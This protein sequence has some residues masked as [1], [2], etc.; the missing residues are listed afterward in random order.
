MT[1]K[2]FIAEEIPS[3]NKGEAAI[4]IGALESF[5]ILGDVK[6]SLLSF[7]AEIDRIRYPAKV[8]IIDAQ[9]DLHLRRFLFGN[10]LL[11][12]I[13]REGF[14]AFQLFLFIVFYKIFGS[15]VV[16]LMKAEIWKEYLNS[17]VIVIGHANTNVSIG[18]LYIIPF[19]KLLKKSIII[20]AGGTK[21]GGIKNKLL[22]FLARVVLNKVDLIT[23]REDISYK[24]LRNIGI[25]IPPMHVTADLA[26][27]L[28]AASHERILQI[29]SQE[30]ISKQE[31]L[32]GIAVR[33]I[34]LHYALPYLKTSAEKY[35][36]GIKVMAEVVDC[37]IDNFNANILFIPHSFDPD[38]GL[39]DR[40]MAQDIYRATKNK[41]SIKIIMNEYSPEELKGVIG[42][43]DL[44]IGA[45]THAVIGACSMYVPSIAIS[46]PPH[47]RGYGII[48]KMLGQKKWV[49]D[50][51]KLEA[52]TLIAIIEEAW[53]VKDEIRKDLIDR[54]E[55]VKKRAMYNG[56][57]LMNIVTK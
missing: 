56:E 8:K 32:V 15:N 13:S 49:Y 50:V 11:P 4:V 1:T 5:K 37:I 23:L 34:M 55:T 12:K 41:N 24:H 25:N 3:L 27:L 26:F 6:V 33:G 18:H 16:K 48:G 7:H 53:S 9:K 20:Y 52:E 40:H 42:Q 57:L 30:N 19:A 46:C 44:F 22:K 39:D 28:Q 21:P 35:E 2:I 43:C 45:R 29:L 36:K 54:I 31:P 38:E 14:V 10:T 17:D 47:E 51:E